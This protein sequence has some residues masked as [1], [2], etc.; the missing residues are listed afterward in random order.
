[1]RT[2][3]ITPVGLYVGRVL[4]GIRTCKPDMIYLVLAKEDEKHPEWYKKTKE[5]VDFIEK[6]I[7]FFYEDRIKKLSVNFENFIDVFIEINNLIEEETRNTKNEIR[8]LIDITSTPVLP[9]VALINVAAIHR[10]AE[11]YYTP[12]GERFPNQYPLNIVEKDEGEASIVIPII[13]S[14][15]LD[16]LK[17]K[18]IYWKI[19]KQLAESPDKKVPS[20]AKLLELLGK[21]KTRKKDYMLLGRVLRDLEDMGLVTVKHLGKQK[22]VQITILGEAMAR[23]R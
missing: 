3:L 2:I 7:A 5:N 4:R 10:N 23:V 12:P 8:F 1:L 14:K 17:E 16:E 22:E 15:T 18:D 21:E 11:V 13:R 6:Q 19:L 20:L 9:R